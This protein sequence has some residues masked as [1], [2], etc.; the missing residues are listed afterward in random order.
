[1]KQPF[2]VVWDKQ[3]F[4]KTPS[5]LSDATQAVKAFEEAV[6][7]TRKTFGSEAVA[8]GEINRYRFNGIDLPADGAPGTYGLFR[9]LRFAP[10]P[11]GKRVAGWVGND[12]PLAGF[13]DG[14]VM[15]VEFTKPVKAFSILAYGQT[16]DQNSKHSRDQ[17]E[18]YARHQ[19]KK[20]WFTEAEI[21]A[22]LERAYHP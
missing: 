12:K 5:G 20:V 17:I 10:Q 11:D 14:W 1:M 8:W 3:N 21:K 4:A 7:W 19:Y 9:V 2:A 13:G 16:T 6:T 15:A 22:N 18:L